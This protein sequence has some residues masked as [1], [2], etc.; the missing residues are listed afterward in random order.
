MGAATDL[1]AGELRLL[2]PLSLW[3]GILTGPSVWA[4]DLM[5]CYALVKWACLHHREDVIQLILF[6]SLAIVAAAAAV[7]WLALRHTASDQPTDGGDPRERARFMAVL[8][9]ASSAFF[10]LMILTLAIP[11][12]VLDGCQ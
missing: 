2:S 10:A 7:S 12:W 3:T 4:V 5:A 6:G 8:G 1:T 11:D 9:L